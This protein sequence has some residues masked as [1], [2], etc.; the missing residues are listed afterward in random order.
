MCDETKDLGVIYLTAKWIRGFSEISIIKLWI[1][2]SFI[3]NK[4]NKDNNVSDLITGDIKE[5]AKEDCH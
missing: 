1:K 2:I 4:G 5:T 3:N